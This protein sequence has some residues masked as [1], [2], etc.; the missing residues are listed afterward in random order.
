VARRDGSQDARARYALLLAIHAHQEHQAARVFVSWVRGDRPG[1]GGPFKHSNGRVVQLTHKERVLTRAM[2]HQVAAVPRAAG[3][4]PLWSLRLVWG[5]IERHGSRYGRVVAVRVY[6]YREGYRHA[7][8]QPSRWI[9]GD[10]RS[11][12]GARVDGA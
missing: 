1:A 5:P 9:D 8:A 3:E 6:R 11:V 7:A 2:Y 10:G 12:P 4:L